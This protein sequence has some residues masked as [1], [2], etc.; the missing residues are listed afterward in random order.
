M[1]KILYFRKTNQNIYPNYRVTKITKLGSFIYN[2]IN[3][4]NNYHAQ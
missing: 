3:Y 2:I 1:I 4:K